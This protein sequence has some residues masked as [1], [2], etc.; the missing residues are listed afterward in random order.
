MANGLNKFLG[1]T[2]VRVAVKLLV[3]SLVAGFI[4]KVVGWS[5]RDI[6]NA[7]ANFFRKLWNLGFEAIFSSFEYLILGAAVVVPVFFVI[8][9][10]NYRG[11]SSRD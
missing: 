11:S 1:D 8:R 4:M 7:I 2:P 10:L 9:L 6:V 5:P 3:L